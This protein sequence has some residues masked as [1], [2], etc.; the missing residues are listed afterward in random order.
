MFILNM[1]SLCRVV[2]V[3]QHVLLVQIAVEEA[4]RF[5]NVKRRSIA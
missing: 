2:D 4:L 1:I 5:F 3:C